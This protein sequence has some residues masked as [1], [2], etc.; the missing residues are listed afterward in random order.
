MLDQTQ[1]LDP[2]NSE[3]RI[4]AMKTSI[5]PFSTSEKPSL[6]Q[7]GGK[8]MSLIQMTRQGLPVPPGFVLSVAFFQPWLE[9]ITRSME[10]KLALESAPEHW[11]VYCDE[12][13]AL[14]KRQKM[15]P[16]RR[17]VLAAALEELGNGTQAALFAVRSSS[18]EEDLEEL[19][20]AG[21]Y[22][23]IL[24]VREDEL[25][26]AIRQA[27][28]SCFD[29]RVLRYKDE[30]GLPVDQP[31]IAVIVQRQVETQVAGV[32][33]SINPL[34]NC[35][36]EA[37][38]NANHGLGESVV[39]G[40][41]TPDRFIVDKISQTLLDSKVG[42][43]EIAIWLNPDGGTYEGPGPDHTQA[44]I[45][46]DQALAITEMLKSV[47]AFYDKPIDIEWAYQEERLYL[48]QARPIT[49]Y[50]PLPEEIVTPP[51]EPKTLYFDLTLVKWGMPEPLSVIGMDF[52]DIANSGV[53]KMTMGGEGSLE[54]VRTVRPTFGGRTYV[55]ASNSMKVQGRKRI[56]SSFRIMD[57]PSAEIFENLDESEYLPERT[58]PEMKGLLLKMIGQNIGTLWAGLAALR[59]PEAYESKY[60]EV[61][62]SL[63][64]ALR[65]GLPE[66]LSM[67]AYAVQTMNLMLDS[68]GPFM[69]ILIANEIARASLKRIFKDQPQEVRD[70]IV[71]LERALPNN[72]TIDMG[73]ALYKLSTFEEINMVSSGIEFAAR[74]ERR[75]FSSG[76]LEAW[77]AFIEKFGFR[78]P[79]EMDPAA[80][81]FYEHPE[82]IY[83]Q[84]RILADH[85][86]PQNNPQAIYERARVQRENTYRELLEIAR[87]KGR[88][89]ARS[90]MKN[91][92]VLMTFGGYRELPKY[93]YVMVIDRCRRRI[94]AAGQRLFLA[95]RL[96]EPE[97][98]F[99]L[100]LD[101]L[102][103]A[104]ADPSM[105][106]RRL[107]EDNT[108][109]LRKLRNVHA[110]PRV[111][112]S[113]GKIIRPPRR[114]AT[115]G[116]LTGE[117][118]SPGVVQGRVK[119]LH[120][121]DEKP[122]LPGEILVTRATDPGWTPLFINAA[123]VIL[124]VG[125]L[126]QHGALVAREY[127]KPCV[128]GIQDVTGRLSD[129]QLIELDGANGLI[130]MLA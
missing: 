125:G 98:V 46:N 26:E 126:L 12:V 72:I 100:T 106:L 94:L 115:E 14:C 58:P 24:G 48:L 101:Q 95:D 56:A 4:Q 88:R 121:P 25:E 61:V 129:G 110:F 5:Y 52:M 27:F 65:A 51:G 13:K 8:A 3:E 84:L 6:D 82:K 15:D 59:K 38:I 111:I 108:R 118:I 75:E 37:V 102:E 42:E 49:A 29:A 1:T 73:L 41:V 2:G 128:A 18:P 87:Q 116:E 93:H 11:K 85:P 23:T 36:D 74:L 71:Y 123:G 22:Q 20:F 30:H 66:H 35:F 105:D 70:K 76:F 103:A 16:A 64:K 54:F 57:I 31:R 80:P 104:L 113:R 112:D 79:M 21:G 68:M 120:K 10:W 119:V 43:K 53:L 19:S 122:L 34:N 40:Q 67:R 97:Q 114:E 45:S 130:K 86:D 99:D 55:N 109:F 47:E 28:A 83:E 39:S 90:F 127:G 32:A 60:L 91:Y 44:C 7:V 78:S 81:R 117:P 89:P 69:A 124:E 50:V 92:R 96:D 77:D 62:R 63:E 107:A 17:K 9:N 33:F